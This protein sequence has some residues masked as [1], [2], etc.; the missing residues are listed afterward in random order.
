MSNQLCFRNI[1]SCFFYISSLLYLPS[2]TVSYRI[3]FLHAIPMRKC[4]GH[5][6]ISLTCLVPEGVVTFFEIGV[7]PLCSIMLS[8]CI[9]LRFAWYIVS[10]CL[11]L[12]SCCFCLTI[13]LVSSQSVQFCCPAVFALRSAQYRLNL[14]ISVV[15]QYLPYDLQHESCEL[16]SQ[17]DSALQIL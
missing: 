12:L 7:V 11:F 15:L 14:F 4:W 13:G 10:I 2:S 1:I 5:S 3:S 16:F 6:S 9:P 17:L 8:C